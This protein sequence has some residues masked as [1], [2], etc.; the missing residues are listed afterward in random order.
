MSS[1]SNKGCTTR[2]SKS[3]EF[4]IGDMVWGKVK[5]YP[6]WPGYIL[7]ESIALPSVFEN[8]VNGFTLVAF[9]GD[10]SYGWLDSSDLIPYESNF[11]EKSKQTTMKSFVKAVDES[12]DEFS[13]RA[14]L[15]ISCRCRN[16]DN[17]RV[18]NIEDYFSV[19]VAGFEPNG[20]YD[21]RQ[22]E[23]ARSDF[24][25][26][27]MIDFLKNLAM[28][29]GEVVNNDMDMDSLRD[30]AKL[31]ALRRSLFVE[32]DP[33]LVEAFGAVSGKQ[34]EE[35]YET[36]AKKGINVLLLVLVAYILYFLENGSILFATYLTLFDHISLLA[37]LPVYY[38]SYLYINLNCTCACSSYRLTC[39]PL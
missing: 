29:T 2:I 16:S 36:S 9:F 17:F 5:S 34:A 30:L 18:W 10:G 20:V 4:E 38:A 7:D 6:W 31:N 8:K 13:R 3:T 15:G 11:L 39:T 25:S 37:F 33:T 24:R 12:V 32:K 21:R 22:I 26:K 19:D 27:N 35:K 23:L 1:I 28:S 14:A